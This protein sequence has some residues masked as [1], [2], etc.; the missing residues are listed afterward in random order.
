MSDA[1]R[2]DGELPDEQVAH[3]AAAKPA[4]PAKAETE[5]AAAPEPTELSL[6]RFE[7]A[8]DENLRYGPDAEIPYYSAREARSEGPAPGRAPRDW[9]RLRAAASLT[10]VLAIGAAA[11]AAHVHALRVAHAEETQTR[12]LTHRLDAMSKR[13][14]TLQATRSRDEL[15]TIRKVL[16]EIKTGA[17]NTRDMGGAVSQLASHVEKLEKQQGARLD[18]LGDRIDHD[19]AARLVSVTARLEKLEA[20]AAAAAAAA[21]PAPKV[22]VAKASPGVSYAP[23]GSINRPPP[24]LRNFYLAQIRNG[25]AMIGSPA[26]EFAV[27]PGDMVPGGG[28]VL[29]IERRGRDWVVV[30]T[31]GQIFAADE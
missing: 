18:K 11:A 28:R 23:T 31:Q 12:V 30:T 7:S 2:A 13:L 5:R 15:A 19:A 9:R 8:R 20:K 24:R 27:E 3:D 22:N 14:E 6:T 26:G 10:A 1:A 25:Y 21:K 29:R 4:L 17:A 16:A